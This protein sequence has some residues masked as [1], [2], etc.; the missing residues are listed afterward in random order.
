MLDIII[1]MLRIQDN[2]FQAALVFLMMIHI[3]VLQK[4]LSLCLVYL[5]MQEG[6]NWDSTHIGTQC[7]VWFKKVSF[8][9]TIC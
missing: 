8:E 9:R 5:L 1:E 2:N 6:F 7:V 3:F 4:I